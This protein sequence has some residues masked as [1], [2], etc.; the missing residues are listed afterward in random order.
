MDRQQVLDDSKKYSM[1][2]W[3]PQKVYT[4]LVI[5]K[6]EDIYLYDVDGTRYYDMTSQLINVNIGYNNP[7][8]IKAIQDQAAELCCIAPRHTYPKRAELAKIIIE[9]LAPKNMA[10]VLFTSGGSDANEYALR[11]A[12]VFTGKDKVLSK[13]E[14]YHGSTY[15]AA[16][17]NGEAERSSTFPTIPGFIKFDAPH[18]YTYDLVFNTEEEATAHFLARLEYLIDIEGKDNIAALF[19]ETVTGSNGVHLYPK[20]YLKGVRELCTKYGIVMVCD[21]VMSGFLRCGEWFACQLEGVEPDIITSAKGLNSGYAPLGAVILNKEISAFLDDKAVLAGMTYNSHALCI[22]P[23]IANIREMQRLK[24]KENVNTLAPKL[25][26]ILENLKANHPSIGDVRCI[27]LLGAI[28]FVSD[29]EKRKLM[30]V[31]KEGK[32][33]FPAL[34]ANMYRNKIATVGHGSCIMFAPILTITEDQL[35]ELAGVVD[36]ALYWVD[37]QL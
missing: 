29:R 16:N 5:E 25:K 33:F 8:I 1:F 3:V 12:K 19:I 20:G 4:P 36:K 27:G 23:A 31:T 6:I 26:K 2:T 30:T 11:L 14:S 7:A 21:E 22:A 10:K 17:L 13:F 28:E 9:E 37:E 24:V 34:I 35:N 18:L 32:P 15:G